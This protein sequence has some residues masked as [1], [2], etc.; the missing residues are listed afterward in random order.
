L[1][2]DSFVLEAAVQ[3]SDIVI[4]LLTR[5]YEH[6]KCVS[7]ALRALVMLWLTVRAAPIRALKCS[8]MILHVA[9][10]MATEYFAAQKFDMAKKWG[11]TAPTHARRADR[12]AR[13]CRF[14]DSISKTYRREQWWAVLA[15]ILR[16]ASE[17]AARTGVRM[18]AGWPSCACARHA[19]S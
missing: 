8:R 12:A 4:D 7:A 19:D 17:C 15:N 9:S 14:F 13:V 10:L 11:G 18:R 6:F 2:G 16:H 5:A 3:H 1:R